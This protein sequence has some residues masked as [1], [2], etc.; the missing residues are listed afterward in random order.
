MSNE[1]H[2]NRRT[3]LKGVAAL[4]AATS[5]AAVPARARATSAGSGM[6]VETYAS[7]ITNVDR[8][9]THW[10]DTDAGLVLVDA[11]RLLPEA[12]RAVAF[13]TRTGRSIAAVLVTHA[14]TDHYAG[15][16]AIK[17]AFPDVAIYATDRTRKTIAE[18]THGFN[19]SRRERHGEQFP[20]QAQIS[21]ALPTG[22]LIHGQELRIGGTL[23]RIAE[24][25]PGESDSTATIHLPEHDILFP[26]DFVQSEKVPVPFH[27]HE[28]WLAQHEAA[29]ERFPASTWSYHGHGRPRPLHDLIAETRDYLVAA[30]DLARPLAASAPNFEEAAINDAADKLILR[31]PHH[32]PGGG[33][34]R[35]G[36]VAAVVRRIA[37]QIAEGDVA[38]APFVV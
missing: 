30:R 22:R 18:D 10:F 20:T 36:M 38:E 11:Q 24:L 23:L 8:V 5:A 32:V 27:S 31:Y 7:D 28:T 21:S 4:A 13:A 14:H 34:S 17:A 33:N 16:V 25:T 12:E 35:D 3:L 2:L 6:R 1:D 37:T 29:R 9:N 19:A 26:G 15:L